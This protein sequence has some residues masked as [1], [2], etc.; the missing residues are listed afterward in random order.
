M[1]LLMHFQIGEMIKI[2]YPIFQEKKKIFFPKFLAIF[3]HFEVA[4]IRTKRE[5]MRELSCLSNR[6]IHTLKKGELLL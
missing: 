2:D 4:E 3:K 6:S 5:V 1:G